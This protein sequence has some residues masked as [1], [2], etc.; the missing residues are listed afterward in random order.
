MAED[1]PADDVDPR[2]ALWR[3]GS[4]EIVGDW[5]RPA[6]ISVLDRVEDVSDETLDGRRLLDLATGSGAVAIEAA[7]RGAVVV[8]VD[9]TDELVEIARRRAIDAGVDVRF[10]VGDFDRLDEALGDTAI[11]DTAIGEGRF[12]VLTSAFGVIFA[13]DAKATLRRLAPL[14]RVGGL[15]GVNGWDPDGV[16]V[17]PESMIDLFPQRPPMPDMRTWTTGIRDLC[18]GTPFDV[19]S[20]QVDELVIPFASVEHCSEQF[21]RWSGGWAQLFETFDSLGVGDEARTRF[22]AHLASFSTPTEDGIELRA[23]YSTSV[24]RRAR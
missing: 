13:P 5:L 9:L 2:R 4:Y 7:R 8:G 21:E 17:V 18:S 19:V 14:M 10:E 3:R 23:R 12:D 24:L 22:S 15:F 11:D 6:S 1:G 20:T 16:L